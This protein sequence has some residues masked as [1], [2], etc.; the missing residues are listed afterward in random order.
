VS[1]P[2]WP[3]K[4]LCCKHWQALLHTGKD[5]E[6]E[7]SFLAEDFSLGSLL[8]Q[9]TTSFSKVTKCVIFPRLWLDHPSDTQDGS[10][11]HLIKKVTARK[12]TPPGRAGIFPPLIRP[13][14]LFMRG[15]ICLQGA[16]DFVISCTEDGAAHSP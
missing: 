13:V 10:T 15:A 1:F 3:C 14:A 9:L 2:K 4:E 7:F 16:L 12:P 11:Q 5:W 8:V 6:L